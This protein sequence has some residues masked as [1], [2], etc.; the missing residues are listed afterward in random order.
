MSLI[1]YML[2]WKHTERVTLTPEGFAY[3]TIAG[4]ITIGSMIRNINLL[5]L[6][7]GIMFAPLLIN[8][9]LAVHRLRTL[10]VDDNS[11]RK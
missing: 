9:R 11:R 7:T 5:I 3:L 6:M 10:R 4:F 8:W 1:R 2:K